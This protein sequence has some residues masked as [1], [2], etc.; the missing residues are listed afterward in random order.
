M[1]RRLLMALG[2]LVL[3]VLIVG[4]LLLYDVS[5]AR[6]AMARAEEH[7]GDLRSQVAEGDVDAART[8]L[9]ELKD[10]TR[11]AESSTDGPL[12]SVAKRVPLLGASF[13][14]VQT[15]SRSLHRVADEGLEPLVTV[16]D[17]VNA[18]VFSPRN[19][20]IDLEAIRKVSPE[21]Q[22]ADEALTRGWLDIRSID[23]DDLIQPMRGRVADLQDKIAEARS[24]VTAGSNAAQLIPAMLGGDGRRTYILV[25]QNNA[26]IRSTGGLP[27]AFSIV[28]TDAGRFRM[29]DQG[30][31]GEFRRFRNLSVKPTKEELRLYSTLL[32]SFWG[33][34]TFT[35][36]FPRS[37]EIMRAMMRERRG[38]AAD[39][40]VSVDPIALSYILEA[41]GPV[42]LADGRRLTSKNAV[43]ALLNDVYLRIPNSTARDAY[44]ADAA[45]RVFRAV[46][47][48]RGGSRA[49]LEGLARGT[50]ENRI[51]IASARA[52]EQQILASTRIGGV[53]PRD[54][55]TTPHLGI[56]YNDATETKLEY[57][58]RK[59][60]TV[61]ATTCTDDG[62][63]TLTATTQLRSVAPRNA[64]RLPGSILGPGTGEKRG[65]FRVVMAFYAP[66]GGL[67]TKLKI[68]GKEQPLNRA[69]HNGINVVSIPILLAP[70]QEVTVEAAMFTGKDQRGD[71]IVT[72]TPGIQPTPNHV[73]VPSACD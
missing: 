11:E 73:A 52:R 39:G 28:R 12:W 22:R 66:H 43:K 16:A 1:R 29:I 57:Y 71:P 50:R 15:I 49:L 55:G 46:V 34:T 27:G 44:F 8:S 17:Q 38:Q 64:S 61:R 9:A 30:A 45:R 41:T 10:A 59:S 3:L 21:L 68:D 25:F 14:A 33:D 42:R 26:E 18:D 40:V 48:G 4:L 24:T 37:A 51:L 56:Y 69:E 19:G 47:E 53:Q 62:T 63:Q 35:P 70:G 2:F 31:G 54:E 72:T 32:T 67:V 7:A 5:E 65:S 20:R 23:P 6:A 13:D 58:F 36:D 60:T